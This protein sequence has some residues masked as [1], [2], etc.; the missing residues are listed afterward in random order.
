MCQYLLDKCLHMYLFLNISTI[1]AATMY[2][3]LDN[4]IELLLFIAIE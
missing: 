3:V 1:F 2:T 4:L